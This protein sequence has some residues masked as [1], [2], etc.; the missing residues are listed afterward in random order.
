M[1]IIDYSPKAGPT[2]GNTVIKVKG[3]GF[4]QFK[5]ENGKRT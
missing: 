3:M 5:D 2:Y 1:F 4:D